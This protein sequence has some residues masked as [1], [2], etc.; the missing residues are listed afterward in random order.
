MRNS[1][2]HLPEKKQ[3]E[4]ITHILLV[5][6]NKKLANFILADLQARG[7]QLSYESSGDKAVYRILAEQPDIVILDV[8]LPGFNGIQVCQSVRADYFGMILML[9]ALGEDTDHLVGLKSGADDYIVKPINPE[10]LAARILALQRRQYK[11]PVKTQ[12][13]FGVLQVDLIARRVFLEG[14]HIILKPLE[15]ELLA[16][17]AKNADHPV[18]RDNI[19]LALRGISYD[20]VDRSIDLRIS[21][22]RKKLYDDPNEPFRIKTVRGKGY[23]L[24]STAWEHRNTIG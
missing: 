21:Y 15:F 10:V 11:H 16:F 22:L 2:K 7:Y 20:G 6:D 9:T 24:I 19:M 8:M 3:K 14:E 12:I 1:L 17:L 13:Q 18:N 4:K 5:E 23:I